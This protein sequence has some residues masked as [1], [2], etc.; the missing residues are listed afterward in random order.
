M[1]KGIWMASVVAIVLVAGGVMV[2]KNKGDP[3]PVSPAIN[4]G[5]FKDNNTGLELDYDQRLSQL[6]RLTDQE[7]N[8][9]LLLR[10]TD[11]GNGAQQFLVSVRYEKDLAKAAAITKQTLLDHL[12]SS[13]ELTLPKKTSYK[14]LALDRVQVAGRESI[15]VT[16]TY[17]ASQQ[18]VTRQR[19]LIIPIDNDKAVYV[20]MQSK[21][22]DFSDVAK[23]LFDPL[24]GS[25]KL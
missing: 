5:H 8:D 6:I 25:I 13:L 17:I 14:Q 7:I 20:A 1:K 16:F 19:L 24:Q 15:Q 9:Q 10:L 21:D 2:Y 3:R 18:T 22:S 4:F 11:K 12:Q 23:Q